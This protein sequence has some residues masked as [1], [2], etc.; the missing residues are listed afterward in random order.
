MSKPLIKL[1][2][3]LTKNELAAYLMGENGYEFIDPFVEL[4]TDLAAVFNNGFNEYI[5]EA[6]ENKD[7]D[8]QLHAAFNKLLETPV[9]TWWLISIINTYLFGFNENALRFNIDVGT[10]I[11]PINASLQKFK[12]E[13]RG[14]KSWVGARY[15]EGLLEDATKKIKKINV[16]LRSKRMEELNI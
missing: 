8:R 15:S 7:F 2:E 6:G 1:K 12:D 3:A 5:T 14:N 10:M 4:P 11:R 13:L 16:Y 9:G